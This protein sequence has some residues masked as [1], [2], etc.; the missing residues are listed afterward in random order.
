M[1][2]ILTYDISDNTTRLHFIKRLQYFGLKRL[3]KSVFIGYMLP[4]DRL[5]LASEF[6]EYLSSPKDSIVLFPLCGNCKSSILL[7]GEV[8]IPESDLKYRFL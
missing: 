3:Q 1:L 8:E 2:T 6:E 5:D 4:K 7:D